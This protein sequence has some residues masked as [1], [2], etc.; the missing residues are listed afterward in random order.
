MQKMLRFHR[1]T[2]F[3]NLLRCVPFF[4]GAIFLAANST[5]RAKSEPLPD[6]PDRPLDIAIDQ[7]TRP[8]NFIIESATNTTTIQLTAEETQWI[9]EHNTIRIGIDPEFA[10][11]EYIDEAGNPQGLTTDYVALLNSRLGLNMQVAPNLTWA[12]VMARTKNREIDVLPSIGDTRERQKY[13]NY[14]KPYAHFLRV[15]IT[16]D[17]AAFNVAGLGDLQNRRVAVQASSSH[18][19]YL[20]DSSNLTP[21]TYPTLQEALIELSS[22]K[23]DALVGNVASAT[24]WIRK[25]NLT[26]L[27]IASKV[28]DNVQNLYFASRNDW[29]LLQ[30]ILQK[31]LNSITPAEQIEINRR[32]VSIGPPVP[33]AKTVQLSARETTWLVNHPTISFTGD[34]DWLPF[35][36]FNSAGEY[37]GI[38]SELINS[39]EQRTGVKFEHL[40]SGSWLNALDMAASGI[41]DVISADLADERI[42]RTHTFT[43]PYLERPL[44]IVMRSDQSRYVPDLDEIADRRIAIIDGYGYTWE[45]L[46]RY[47]EIDFIK[48]SSIQQALTRLSSG[49]VDALVLTITA[50][51][52]QINQLGFS[53]LRIVGDLP[54]AMKTGLAVRNDWPE[55]LGI[56]NKGIQ[57]ITPA[58]K[59]QIVEQWMQE[60]HV[61]RIDYKLIKQ[62]VLGFIIALLLLLLWGFLIRRQRER[63]RVS[64]ERFQLAMTAAADGI[65]DWNIHTGE[66][67][68]SPG[69]LSMLG[70]E[71]SE[72]AQHHQTWEALLHPRDKEQAVT[73]L[74]EAVDRC[75]TQYENQFRLRAKD[76]SY[77]DIQ[78][79]GGVVA[80]DSQG[81]ALRA[82][83]THTDITGRVEAE[84]SLAVFKR[85]AETSSQGFSITTLQSKVTYVND[86]LRKM[87]GEK[88]PEAIYQG[89]Y[90]RYYL[91]PIVALFEEEITPILEQT[92]HWTGELTLLTTHGGQIPTLQNFFVIDDQHGKPRYVGTVVTDIS[93][94]KQTQQALQKAQQ[95]ADQ[96]NQFK[97][98]FLA[99]MSHEVR[100]PLN[101][102]MGMT[103]LAQQTELTPRQSDYLS[104]I[105]HSSRSLLA[106]VN[107]IL[108][109][110]KIEAG[111]L[112]FEQTQFKLEEIFENLSILQSQSSNENNVEMVYSIDAEIPPILS[113][114]PL[115]LGQ[116][117]NNLTS[118]AVKFT[119]QGE[120]VVSAKLAETQANS[121]KLVFSVRDTGIGIEQD[122][123]ESLFEPFTQT[124]GSTTRKYGGT[125]LGL[126]IC[127]RLVTMMGGT[128]GVTSEPGIGSTFFFDAEFPFVD[129]PSQLQ[130]LISPNLR[131]L[132]VLL[133]D[134][135][136][137]TRQ[138]LL[139]MLESFS[140]EVTAVA[141]GT[142]ALAELNH[143][144]TDQPS[145]P[146]Q[147][148]LMDWNMP[149]MNGVEACRLM[150]QNSTQ[151]QIPTIIMLTEHEQEQARNAAN[152]VDINCFLIK[153]VTATTLFETV[154]RTLSPEHGGSVTPMGQQAPPVPQL[155]GTKVL[156]VE[157]NRINQQ[158]AQELLEKA[159][160]A[161]QVADDGARAV[162]AIMNSPF[163]LVLMDLQMP[164]M[165]GYQATQIIR[166]DPRFKNLPIVAMTAHALAG[167]REKCLAAGMNDYIAKPIDPATF[168]ATLTKWIRLQKQAS[169]DNTELT[170]GKTDF[171]GIDATEGLLRVGGNVELYQRLLTEFVDDHGQDDEKLTTMLSENNIDD[172]RRLVHTL[173]GVAGNI[174]ASNLQ[175][176][177]AALEQALLSGALVGGLQN[178][179]SVELRF[180][181]QSL[182]DLPKIDNELRAPASLSVTDSASF[183]P[184]L[185]DFEQAL[186]EGDTDAKQKL[187]LC[188]PYLYQNT[189]QDLLSTLDKQIA[190]FDYDDALQ[191]L[192]K[193]MVNLLDNKQH[194]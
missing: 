158:V 169:A 79:R 168:Y 114:D 42:R 120:I 133:A 96:A 160:I 104:K 189:A 31:G 190:H 70:Y 25:L 156:V 116:V 36:S 183:G 90:G 171:P 180:L 174:G 46:E 109:F 29:P 121:V 101:A 41:A 136:P 173:R 117:L 9:A 139:E 98:E 13:L 118:N 77:R 115:R 11:F 68:L 10:P 80:Q 71:P 17:D 54:V 170:L 100:T 7:E 163:D 134:D 16:R 58:E 103:H 194:A 78:S 175:R 146:Y 94:Q 143:A 182:D 151:P 21:L 159:G 129:T 127:N 83:G 119:H 20:L 37:T 33:D 106:V 69:Y 179:L 48:L 172:A 108:D 2:V 45:L 72:L 66:T 24:Y 84:E 111:H 95:Q 162:K 32:W 86:T 67:Y 123:I 191:T 38:V 3:L 64:D 51:S 40:P 85:F 102:I 23:V 89:N 155:Q 65:W 87:L 99:N 184:L 5:A 177:S 91:E 192:R 26:N 130:D 128:V 122:Q 60:K 81:N 141:S 49:E 186:I 166:N 124:D 113:G 27:K 150:H 19:G 55:L 18:D 6:V 35:E 140:F 97:S 12:E 142:A 181:I 59:Q 88:S 112:Q 75:D 57:T 185:K 125:G 14:S 132:R 76:G 138:V 149:G 135:R 147:L 30:S 131:R 137:S 153:P 52:Y 161:V 39:L 4:L 92:G 28:S 63:L 148:V 152:Q 22:G 105:Q 43:K 50:A 126:T 188:R 144:A 154:E 107:D 56:L 73:D 145:N 165:D 82:V 157:D 93:V 61:E 53:N 44:G 1:P 178:H 110:S 164:D 62:L 187:Q 176:H 47:P 34:P 74:N 8:D 193:I 167:A 15:I